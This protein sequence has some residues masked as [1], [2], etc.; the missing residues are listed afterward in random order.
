MAGGKTWSLI[1]SSKPGQSKTSSR[2]EFKKTWKG[3][4][5][6]HSNKVYRVKIL[7]FK[8]TCGVPMLQQAHGPYRS[9]E[10]P[11]QINE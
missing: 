5:D 1:K 4:T 7:C 11:V 10:K 9:P 8:F 2:G 6:L 3:V